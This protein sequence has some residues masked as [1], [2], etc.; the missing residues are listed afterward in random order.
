LHSFW[1]CPLAMTQ[2]CCTEGVSPKSQISIIICS[3]VPSIPIPSQAYDPGVCGWIKEKQDFLDQWKDLTTRQQ[4]SETFT[5][6]WESKELMELNS[7]IVAFA[8]SQAGQEAAKW[9]IPPLPT[10]HTQTPGAVNC[11]QLIG[12]QRDDQTPLS[13]FGVTSPPPPPPPPDIPKQLLA[14]PPDWQHAATLAQ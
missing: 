3:T 2:E 13:H 5:L 1:G 4:S 10:M 6:V 11:I 7:A 14:N 9:L 12:Q 8:A